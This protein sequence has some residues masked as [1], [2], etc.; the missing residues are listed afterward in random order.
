MVS[1]QKISVYFFITNLF[2]IRWVYGLPVHIEY[3][4]FPGTAWRT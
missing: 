1:A 3:V 4:I 2:V